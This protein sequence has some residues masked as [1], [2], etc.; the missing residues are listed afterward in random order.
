MI[1][2]KRRPSTP[3]KILFKHHLEPNEITVTR[4]AKAA[5]LS[6]KHVSQIVHGHAALSPETAVK[7][8]AVLGTTPEL[9]INLQRAVDLWD[10]RQK[11]KGWEPAEALYETT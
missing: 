1:T 4:F 2:R 8:A 3:G 6:Q 9:W 11:L 7:F 10:A 5:K